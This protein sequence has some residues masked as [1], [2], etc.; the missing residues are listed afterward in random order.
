MRDVPR[1]PT[2]TARRHG[3]RMLMAL[4]L[5]A[6]PA[7]ADVDGEL[8]LPDGFAHPNGITGAPDGSL[9]VGSVT[10]GD[11]LRIAPDGSIETWFEET[12]TI[13]A[14]TSLWLDPAI[15]ILWV[16]SPDVLGREVDGR[17]VRRAHRLAA[18]DV[19]RGEEV[20][21]SSM[22]DGGFV[23]DI[24]LDGDGGVY[25]TDSLR[26]RILRRAAPDAPFEVVADMAALSPGELGPAGIVRLPDG[27]LIV[28]LYSEGT[29]L[30]IDHREIGGAISSVLPLER[31]IAN[32]DGLA[33]APDG[34]LLVVDGAVE[35]GNGVLLAVDLDE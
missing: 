9:Y 13:F 30:R 3:A 26:D 29:L 25:V 18:I 15:G 24:A 33:L 19:A 12:E 27:D 22:P 23:N 5:V 6:Q 1:R 7:G 21:S 2:P 17:T 28:G 8:P 4:A 10:T 14:G 11:Q 20:W 31:A 34:R 35:S 32:P 16:A